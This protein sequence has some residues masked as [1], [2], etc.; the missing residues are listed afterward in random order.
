MSQRAN[1]VNLERVT[2]PT[3]SGSLLDE[4]SLGVGEGDRIG[5]VG[6]NGDGKTTLLDLIAGL[7]EPDRAGSRAPA[8]CRSA[9]SPSATSSTTT[10][11]VREVVLGG[12][13]D[14]EWAAD[15]ATREVVE[16]LLAGLDL[17]RTVAGLSG[18]ERRRCS[19][20]RLLL[21]R[22][23][24]AAARR[25]DQPPRRRGGRLAGRH[26]RAR[27]RP[28]YVRA[29]RGHPRPLVPRRGLHH[30][31][32]GAPAQRR[33]GRRRVRR[34]VRRVRARQGRAQPP[35]RGLGVAPAEPDAQ[36]AR[37]AA[38]RRAR[39]APRS[40]SSGWTPPAR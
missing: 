29:G 25:A 12:R 32:G 13:A 1:L 10:A 3:A 2:R 8:A 15:T 23:R 31:L 17:D 26:L 11:T 9:T 14:H 16:E 22:P 36:G 34:R 21:E 38:P 35:G 39:R 24:P 28:S 30:D 20:A 40:R 33:R 4:V 6:R 7:E 37:V 27:P 19:L 5:V 18:G